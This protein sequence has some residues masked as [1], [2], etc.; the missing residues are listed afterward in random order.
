MNFQNF[1]QEQIQWAREQVAAEKDKL[2]QS[3]LNGELEFASHV[4]DERKKTRSIEYKKMADEIRE[5]EHDQNLTT[6]QKMY[7]YLTGESVPLLNI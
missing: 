7:Y 3:C 5:G 2:S 6:R 1:T 4:T